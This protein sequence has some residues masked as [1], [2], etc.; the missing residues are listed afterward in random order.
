M[1]ESNIEKILRLFE[2]RPGYLKKGKEWLAD[3]MNVSTKEIEE[4]KKLFRICDEDEIYNESSNENNIQEFNSHLKKLGLKEKDVKSIKFWQTQK[5]AVRYS[6]VTDNTTNPFPDLNDVVKELTKS[7]TPIQ[8]PKPKTPGNKTLVVFLSDKH[9]GALTKPDAPYDNDYNESALFDRLLRIV[10]EITYI[11]KV[12][13]TLEK[14]VLIDLGDALDGYNAQTVRGGHKLPQNMS[15]K[16]AFEVFI[17]LHKAFY[18]AILFSGFASD[19]EIYHVTNSNHGGEF[20]YFAT[21]SLQEYF[22][23]KVPTIIF[24][25]LEQFI[26][27]IEIGSHT[28]LLSHG[29]DSDDIKNGLPLVLDPKTEQYIMNYVIHHN[30][31]TT[32]LHF[33]K[34]D[35]HQ[36]STQCGKHFR[37]RNIPSVYGSSKWIMINYGYTKPGCGF[38]LVDG[39]TIHQ[40]EL[41]L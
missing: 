3:K 27:P 8:I 1:I 21:R 33:I 28:Y 4:A 16:E 25:V 9:I 24:E 17:R 10:K 2:N 23:A 36:A 31:P 18:R 34:G 39:D 14:I 5:G 6:I 19:Y 15:N 11:H 37:Y 13:G 41:W 26:T 30:I 32:N 22:K 29:K 12:H 7:V 40:W 20:E 35:L 38:D